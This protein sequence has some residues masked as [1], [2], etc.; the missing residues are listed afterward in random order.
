MLVCTVDIASSQ[1]NQ[2]ARFWPSLCPGKASASR[3]LEAKHA[4]HNLA[5]EAEPRELCV[6]FAKGTHLV[7]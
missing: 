1:T 5:A 7:V 6:L 2:A 3:R 4:I